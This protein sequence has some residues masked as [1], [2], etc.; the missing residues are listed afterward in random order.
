MLEHVVVISLGCH[1][2]KNFVRI[3]Y[4]WP[5]IFKYCMN[6]I[7]K[8]H[9]CQ[10]FTHKMC[11]HL[12][13]L[14][15]VVVIGPFTKWGIDFMTCKPTSANGHGYIIVVVDYFT[16]WVKALPTFSND[17]TTTKLFIFNHIISWFNVPNTIVID[18]GSHF[19]NK[20]MIEL[21]VR[22]GFHM[23]TQHLIILSPMVR[24]KPLIMY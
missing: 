15:P 11:T 18:H 9:P 22:L 12:S 13:P 1:Y 21:A 23:R 10:V 16:K 8:C 6:A 4:F 2:P 14:H 3:G 19:H 7:Q 20:M 17:G 5:T 24:L